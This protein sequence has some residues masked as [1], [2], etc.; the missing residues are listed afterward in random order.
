MNNAC[1]LA[2]GISF[3]EKMVISQIN[4]TEYNKENHQIFTLGNN[5]AVQNIQVETLH[6]IHFMKYALRPEIN[7]TDLVQL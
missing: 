6:P 7:I 4:P 3:L 5:K 1:T 2:S